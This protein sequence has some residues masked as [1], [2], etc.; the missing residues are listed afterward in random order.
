VLNKFGYH[1]ALHILLDDGTYPDNELSKIR[2]EGTDGTVLDAITRFPIAAEGASSYLRLPQRLSESMEEDQTAA[3]VFARWPEIKSPF[4]EDLRRMHQFSPVLGRFVTFD[5]YFQHTDNPG[6]MT[7]FEQREYLSPFLLQAVAK[8]EP[9][10]VSRFRD[11]F[12]RRAQFDAASWYHRVAAALVG[13]HVDDA[14]LSS[15]EK[16]VEQAG[17][18]ASTEES[19]AE[20]VQRQLDE[21]HAANVQ[22]LSKIILQSAGKGS[23]YLV[24]NPLSFNRR[25]VVDLPDAANPPVAEGVIKAVQFDEHRKSVVVDVPGSGFAWIAI[26]DEAMPPK[27]SKV[28]IAEHGL[29]QNEFFQVHISE[30]TGG[31]SQFKEHGRSPN[32]LSQQLAFRF[33]NEQT[34]EVNKG[35]EGEEPKE[36]RTYYSEMRCHSLEVTSDGPA[37]GEI[38]TKGDLIDQQND[39][40]LAGFRQVFRVWR[41]KPTLEIEIEIDV[42]TKP[43]GNPW[44]SYYGCRFA[45]NDSTA[46]LTQS[47]SHSALPA[48]GDRIESPYFLEIANEQQ[49]TTILFEGLAFHR[50]TGDR[51]L[52]SV[53]V[54]EGEEKR[55]F[56]F[57]VAFDQ[58]YP[59]QEALNGLVP[60]S[61]VPATGPPRA[62]NTGWFFHVNTPRVQ[63]TRVL[64]LMNEPPVNSE[65][66]EQ[67]DVPDS[68]EGPGFG[69]RLVETEGRQV[70]VELRC[71]QTPSRARQRDFH[72]RT[73]NELTI[74]NDCVK[75]EMTAHEI[76]DIELF[77]ESS[78]E[79]THDRHD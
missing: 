10:P 6:R 59:M 48:D 51:M 78:E 16:I 12:L 25:V 40:R 61:V 26:P 65:P 49:R 38:V 52:D 74:E 23:G 76:A 33:P 5:D 11:H 47:V 1:S 66:W 9:N 2:W 4:F 39:Q 57:V 79:E 77:F 67:Y 24:L 71:F 15:V 44:T 28:P 21:F 7:S 36:R 73:L 60:V 63:I 14:T 42:A 46:S 64:D 22:S 56:R 69:L 34:L 35:E 50:K 30:T 43:E 55:K 32:R 27:V 20:D 17:P 29:L 41:G 70:S 54:T 37:M 53:L 75:I 3:L 58:N 13:N 72:G 31:L 62:G 8:R 19:E 18:D 68:P 45:W